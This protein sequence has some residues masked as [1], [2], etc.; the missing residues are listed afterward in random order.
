MKQM[1]CVEMEANCLPNHDGCWLD[2]SLLDFT[3]N[4]L[5]GGCFHSKKYSEAGVFID[6]MR[7]H[8]F[9]ADPSTTSVLLG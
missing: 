3:Y 8:G 1:N 9:S 7:A 4:T 2:F 6:E 5:I